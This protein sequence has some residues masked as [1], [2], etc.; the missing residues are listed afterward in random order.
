MTA[1]SDHRRHDE[2]RLFRA[3]RAGDARAREQLVER[4][5]PLARSLARR[6]VRRGEALE[7]LEQVASLALVKAID[8]FDPARGA[9]F[10]SRST[11]CASPTS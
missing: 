11:S 7:D 10:S 3:H 2:L 9:A 8:G 6:Y 1:R 5:L 4:Y